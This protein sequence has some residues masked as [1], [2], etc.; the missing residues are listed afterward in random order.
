MK[1]LFVLAVER[2]RARGIE[3]VIYRIS[4]Q[5]NTI[6]VGDREEFEFFQEL[7]FHPKRDGLRETDTGVGIN[8]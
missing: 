4:I 2:Y 3:P 6:R 1:N 7:G 5:P 8:I